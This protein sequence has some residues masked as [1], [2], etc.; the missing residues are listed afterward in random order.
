MTK[1]CKLFFPVI[2]TVLAA[3]FIL[4]L[5]IIISQCKKKRQS[6]VLYPKYYEQFE[7]QSR[8]FK[9]QK[10][11]YYLSMQHKLCLDKLY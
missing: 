6:N 10:C 3:A 11:G 7:L 1:L 2:T 8:D 5:K 9:L 4:A